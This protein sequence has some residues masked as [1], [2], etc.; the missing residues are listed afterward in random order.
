EV[1]KDELNIKEVRFLR[2]AEE[3]V[4]LRAQPN[5]RVLGKR[6]GGRTQA[7]AQAVRMLPDE[8]LRAFRT[9]GPLAIELDGEQHALSA[10]EVEILEEAQGELVV[11]SDGGYTVALDAALDDALR[12]EGVARELV[13]RVQ[14]LRKDS[15]LAVSDRIRLLVD[16]APEVRAAAEQ[17]AEYIRGE[18]LAV[19]LTVGSAEA[20]WD[21]AQDTDID[22]I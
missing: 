2:G 4:R 9:G 12:T 18:T 11:E 7:A 3:L 19:A 13:S 6:F 21:A 16:G 17:Y 14:R 22:G 20:L 1:V 8:Q 10:D 15:G 5:F